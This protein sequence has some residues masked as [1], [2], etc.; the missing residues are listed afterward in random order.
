MAV[1]GK[2]TA[3]WREENPNVE[4]ANILLK[5]IQT[6]K[7]FLIKTK[8]IPNPKPLPKIDIDKLNFQIPIS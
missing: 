7:E 4:P 1:Q 5:R 6:D 3:K 2:L 8:V